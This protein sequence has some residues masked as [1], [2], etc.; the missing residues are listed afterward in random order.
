MT[1]AK[2]LT[3]LICSGF[4]QRQIHNLND[5]DVW[6]VLPSTIFNSA[7]HI[8]DGDLTRKHHNKDSEANT[9]GQ[10]GIVVFKGE[11]KA[12]FKNK[13]LQQVKASH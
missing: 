9:V 2:R 11:G 1:D 10:K 7:V 6:L 8:S 12:S 4:R 5:I 13:T 3:L